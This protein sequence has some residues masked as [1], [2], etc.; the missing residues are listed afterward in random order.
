MIF[1]EVLVGN[2]SK[3]ELLNSLQFGDDVSDET[4]GTF[5]FE[6]K[7]DGSFKKRQCDGFLNEC[8][9]VNENGSTIDGTVTQVEEPD[10]SPSKCF[11]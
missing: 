3:C 2:F 9:C 11:L 10:C 4:R 6:C 8:W 1:I 7:V 5:L